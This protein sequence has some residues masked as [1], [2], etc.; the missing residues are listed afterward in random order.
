M[1][2]LFHC[3][4]LEDSFRVGRDAM[5][6]RVFVSHSFYNRHHIDNVE[7][8]RSTISNVYES[9]GFEF[10]KKYG[11][12]L[13]F[14][15]FFE[16]AQYGKPL[17]AEIRS[18]I[19]KADIFVMDA[20]GAG[21][22]TFYELGYAHSLGREIAIFEAVTTS[23]SEI[24]TDISDL[25]IGR[26][27]SLADLTTKLKER[28]NDQV[29]RRM[30]EFRRST[31]KQRHRCFWFDPAVS[32]IHVICAPEPERTRF[33]N[34]S[35]TDYLYVDN[36]DDRDALYEVSTFLSRAYPDAKLYRHAASQVSSDV[37]DSN[38][39][40]LGGPRNNSL[41]RDL[42]DILGVRF[43]YA[44]NDNS[45]NFS[46]GNGSF[47]ILQ[48]GKKDDNLLSLDVGYFGR[49][50]NPFNRKNHLV[51]CHGCHTFGTLA[52]C[53]I[54]ADSNQALDNSRLLG[55]K[56]ASD[57]FELDRI[58]CAFEVMIMENRRIVVP[59]VRADRLYFE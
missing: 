33:A 36:L 18:Q 21:P 9:I 13:T 14:D 8:F 55:F 54:F 49:F 22:N 34:Q 50:L 28:M 30:V 48:V 57:P 17:P 31:K 27:K 19:E 47:D 15:V 2:E 4:P 16:D 10:G 44:D 53:L 12:P 6:L 23:T 26:Y 45:L 25:L 5:K 35:S 24:P 41:T 32:E 37:L 1:E 46:L 39:V 40:L 42:A 29:E 59:S 52:A 43:A 7:M 51:M 11:H 56:G 58:E 3:L 38:V 20:A